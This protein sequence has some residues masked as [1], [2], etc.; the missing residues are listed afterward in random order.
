MDYVFYILFLIFISII[1]FLYL[2]TNCK[3]KFFNTPIWPCPY[4]N[5]LTNIYIDKP[6]DKFTSLTL[7]DIYSFTHISHGLIL[8]IILNYFYKKKNINML[9]FVIGWGILWELIEN[10]EYVLSQY[11]SNNKYQRDYIG[12]SIINSIGDIFCCF[13]GFTIGYHYPQYCL[14]LIIISEILLFIKMRDNLLTNTL[15]IFINI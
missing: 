10:T 12:D 4:N 5:R 13:I 7:F 2:F 1:L 15:Q 3:S 9:F 14:L 11:R 8:F 6:D